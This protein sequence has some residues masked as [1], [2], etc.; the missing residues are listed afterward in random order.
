MQFTRQTIINFL[1]KDLVVVSGIDIYSVYCG[2][3]VFV[4]ST[5]FFVISVCCF[6]GVFAHQ[7]NHELKKFANTDS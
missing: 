2:K 6:D 7:N 3:D 4:T 1:S 5:I